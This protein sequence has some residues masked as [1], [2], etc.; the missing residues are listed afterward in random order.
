MLH[1][2]RGVAITVRMRTTI[3]SGQV[4]G[5]HGQLFNILPNFTVTQIARV[6]YLLV[7]ELTDEYAFRKS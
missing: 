5:N 1:Q 4:S 6:F 2:P 7:K 3:S